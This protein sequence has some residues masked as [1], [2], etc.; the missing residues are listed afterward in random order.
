MDKIKNREKDKHNKSEDIF[1][2]DNLRLSQ[3]FSEIAGVKKAIITVPV[4]K[5]NRQ[6]FI[7][8]HPEESFRLETAV[9]EV[10]ED[11]ATYL[12]ET[13]LWGELPG[14]VV[15]KI[16]FTTI[17][18]QGTLTIWPVRLPGGDGRLDQWNSSA[19]EAAN[20]AQSSWIRI[21]ANM[22]L[23]AYEVFEATGDLPDPEWPDLSFEEILRIAF[24]DQFIQ[25]MD[26]IVI[27]RL[28]GAL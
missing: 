11:R 3:N 5:P 18:R 23:G 22:N 10:K 25:D 1:N 20:L 6:E 8:V 28:R 13:N 7:R 16:L 4:R 19:L 2:P 14:E 24:K 17:N 12:V 9:I 27:K 21:A 26:H 15:P